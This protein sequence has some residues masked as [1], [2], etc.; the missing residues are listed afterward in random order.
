MACLHAATVASCGGAESLPSVRG[1]CVPLPLARSQDGPEVPQAGSLLAVSRLA[2]FVLALSRV[3]LLP[4]VCP[5]LLVGLSPLWKQM[6]PQV[7]L[8][9]CLFLCLVVVQ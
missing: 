6:L 5:L 4:L 9:I 8:Y 3:L 1:A 7:W 2:P